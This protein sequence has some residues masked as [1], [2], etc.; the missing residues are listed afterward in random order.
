MAHEMDGLLRERRDPALARQHDPVELLDAEAAGL[1]PSRDE[2]PDAFEQ[3][4]REILVRSKLAGEGGDDGLAGLGGAEN[5][6]ATGGVAASGRAANFS[7]DLIDTYFRQMGD[8]ELL[9]REQEV[10]LAKRIETAQLNVSKS[11]C[12]IPMLVER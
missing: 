10:A 1:A 4:D 12:G 3:P 9:S 5:K 8:A 11:L 2:Q 7:R 6:P